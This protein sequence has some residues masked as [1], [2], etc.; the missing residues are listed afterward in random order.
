MERANPR[1]NEWS[2]VSEGLAIDHV[3]SNTNKSFNKHDVTLKLCTMN[4]TDSGASTYWI[5]SGSVK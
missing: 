1:R 5:D 3:D 2:V 4:G